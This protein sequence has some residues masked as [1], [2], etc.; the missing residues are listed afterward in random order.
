MVQNP[1]TECCPNTMTQDVSS[2]GR[3]E[4]RVERNPTFSSTVSFPCHVH[5]C[6][7]CYMNRIPQGARIS[8]RCRT[9]PITH[10]IREMG[11]Y[12]RAPQILYFTSSSRLGIPS[13]R[14]KSFISHKSGPYL[15][16]ESYQSGFSDPEEGTF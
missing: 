2:L 12:P 1:G 3:F 10:Y 15:R 8:F 14:D 6:Y 7:T 11:M 4:C 5:V 13:L 9:G 16:A